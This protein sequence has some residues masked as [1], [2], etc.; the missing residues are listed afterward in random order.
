LAR[1][2]GFSPCSEV[3]VREY[4][5]PPGR[6]VETGENLTD[7][8]FSNAEQF[9]ETV[10]FRRRRD[11]VWHEVTAREVAVEVTEVAKSLINAGIA[12][13]DRVGLMSKTRYEWTLLDFA[14]WTAGA[15]T[16][17]I[18]ETSSPDQMHWILSDSGARA[19]FVE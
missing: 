3:H 8:V 4:T 1:N 19:V 18:Y 14:I 12:T 17:P 7:I 10:S 13:G 5:S 2:L 9:P 15:V 11:G 6:S 16:V